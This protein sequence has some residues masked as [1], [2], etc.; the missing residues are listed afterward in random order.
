MKARDVMVTPV[1]TLKPSQTVREAAGVFAKHRISAAPVVDDSGRLVGI[2]SEGDLMRRAETG[3]ERSRSWWLAL[4][5]DPQ[6]MAD[7]YTHAHA[8]KVSDLMSRKPIV[9]APDTLLA[10]IATI[11]EKHAIKR[12]PIV[13]NGQL[14]GIVSRAN[15][16]QALAAARPA[17]DIPVGDGAIREKLVSHLKAQPWA[18]V[19]QLNITV[20]DGVVTLWGL[21]SS[22]KERRAIRVAAEQTPG[23]RSVI[24]NLVVPPTIVTAA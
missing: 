13:S 8:Q 14:V 4:L 1:V 21:V 24:D 23:V 16:V 11:L 7:E 5:T 10:D 9:A 19:S 22:D 3:T 15:L 17:L 12:V 20:F 6:M 18:H 2:V